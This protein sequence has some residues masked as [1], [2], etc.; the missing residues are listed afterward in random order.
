MKTPSL[1]GKWF[2][3]YSEVK[4]SENILQGGS[5]CPCWPQQ[6]CIYQVVPN[7]ILNINQIYII[8]FW[9]LRLEIKLNQKSSANIQP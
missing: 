8:Q 9:F 3:M 2:S 7:K 6:F 5:S 4:K 1:S